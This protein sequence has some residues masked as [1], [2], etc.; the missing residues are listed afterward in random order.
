MQRESDYYTNKARQQGYPARSVFKLKE[1]INKYSLLKNKKKILDIGACPGGFSKYLLECL[2][3]NG[4]VV[5]VDNSPHIKISPNI[6]NF[7]FING[8]IFNSLPEHLMVLSGS[9]S[10]IE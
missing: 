2:K 6:K 5:A 9:S 1:I 4:L 10:S 7:K 8:D 3:G